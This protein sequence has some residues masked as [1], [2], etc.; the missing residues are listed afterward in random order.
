MELPDYSKLTLMRYFLNFTYGICKFSNEDLK[1][2]LNHLH[3]LSI[4]DLTIPFFEKAT[5]LLSPFFLL[6]INAM[7]S[8]RDKFS[9]NRFI[10]S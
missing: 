4:M 8:K 2:L 7:L 3:F 6:S 10:P 9:V 1:W 5:I